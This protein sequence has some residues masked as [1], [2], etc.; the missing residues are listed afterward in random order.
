MHKSV[1]AIVLV[2]LLTSGCRFL[3]ITPPPRFPQLDEQLIAGP[4]GYDRLRWSPDGRYLAFINDLKEELVVYDFTLDKSWP[5][6]THVYM[7]VE[8]DFAG[9]LSYI[10][11]RPDLSGSP[12]PAIHDL[13]LVDKDGKNDH[14]I[15]NNLHSPGDFAW[16]R[17]S[18]QL[19]IVHTEAD[20]HTYNGDIYLL[21]ATA[22]TEKL[23]ISRQELGVRSIITLVLSPDETNLLIYGE[24]GEQY[25]HTQ[26][27][28]LL[29][30]LEGQQVV[31]EIAVEQLLPRLK[32]YPTVRG[33]FSGQRPNFVEVNGKRWVISTVN[34]PEG[35]CYNYALFF[36]NI[37]DISKN[38]CIPTVK[39]IVSEVA[40]SPDLSKIAFLTVS[41][42]SVF[43]VMVA[44][45]TPEYRERLEM[46]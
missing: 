15:F 35:E 6:A 39:G 4:G 16:F 17:N 30:D 26:P 2:I 45:L 8:W 9:H 19:L 34:A 3:G 44:D 25:S 18:Q 43:Y 28:F 22:G 27:L 33:T 23:L 41:G 14:V 20:A 11:Y 21:D 46:R 40:I 29:Y 7:G 31:K 13:H 36:L 5:A 37:D 1:S 12:F 38:F 24:R 10:R 42:P 32:D